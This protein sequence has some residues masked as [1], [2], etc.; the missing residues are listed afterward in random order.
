[1]V[2]K[3]RRK[4]P[5]KEGSTRLTMQ[6]RKQEGKALEMSGKKDLVKSILLYDF[7]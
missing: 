5:T 4:D 3:I 6:Q 7:P 1:M 2:R